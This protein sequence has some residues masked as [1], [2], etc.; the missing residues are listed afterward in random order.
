MLVA[1][2]DGTTVPDIS[3]TLQW[4]PVSGAIEYGVNWR[5]AGQP[6]T[7]SDVTTETTMLID[8]LSASTT[9]EWWIEARNDYA[10]GTAS[11]VW[12]FTTPTASAFASLQN[13]S[14]NITDYGGGTAVPGE[15]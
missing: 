4:S 5:E 10:W 7:T 12:Q 1:P 14:R 8:G 6:V 9:H 13:L 2:G 15:Q 11:A 3:V